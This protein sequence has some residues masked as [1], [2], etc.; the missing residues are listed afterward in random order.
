ML[1]PLLLP[2]LCHLL[3]VMIR[4]INVLE[5]LQAPLARTL[6]QLVTSS[7]FGG[8]TYPRGHVS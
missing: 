1:L 4:L 2:G 8:H 7:L 6:S 3:R 5:C